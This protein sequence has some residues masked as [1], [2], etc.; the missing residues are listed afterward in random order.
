MYFLIILHS[1]LFAP[2]QCFIKKYYLQ[3][4]RFQHLSRLFVV[5]VYSPWKICTVEDLLGFKSH[6]ILKAINFKSL[7]QAKMENVSADWLRSAMDSASKEEGI[8]FCCAFVLEAALVVVTNTIVVVLFVVERKLRKKGFVLVI[9]MAVADL[10]VGAVSLPLY[11]YL[12]VG[13]AYQLWPVE[14]LKPLKLLYISWE[15][16]FSRASTI[17]AAFISCERCYAV[18]WPLKHR[19]LSMRPYRIL[20]FVVW[21]FSIIIDFSAIQTWNYLK[22][23]KLIVKYNSYRIIFSSITAAIVCGCNIGIF[24]KF[25]QASKENIVKRRAMQTKRLT[26]TLLFVSTIHVFSWLSVIVVR[27]LFRH[28]VF[29]R[30]FYLVFNTIFIIHYSGSFINPVVYA[31]R[32][33]E[34]KQALAS[35]CLRSQDMMKIES[36]GRKENRPT[37][38]T[39]MNMQVGN[40]PKGPTADH[41]QRFGNR[42]KYLVTSLETKLW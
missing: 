2:R 34:F 39:L 4:Y 42:K 37:A 24:A 16:I 41:L 29:L 12:M 40:L 18:Y 33:P 15:G 1:Q 30:V 28:I 17:S 14:S 25:R 27:Y 10:M 21:S 38:L 20:I 26:K 32:I 22:F 5:K 31:L 11:V 3:F 35:C 19:T 13:I 7:S 8:A 9:N 36:W 6:Y 23:S